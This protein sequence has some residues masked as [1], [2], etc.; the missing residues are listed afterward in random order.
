[1]LV[2]ALCAAVFGAGAAYTQREIST[3]GISS[4]KEGEIVSG[5]ARIPLAPESVGQYQKIV[6]EFEG[7]KEDGRNLRLLARADRFGDFSRGQQLFARCAVKQA[8]EDIDGF[9]YR[10]FLLKD[11]IDGI[12]ADPT[13]SPESKK[14][15]TLAALLDNFLNVFS[16]PLEKFLPQ[17]EAGLAIGML[18]GKTDS[19]SANMQEMFSRT[20]L[21]HIMAVSGSNVTII[22]Q[23]FFLAALSLG[24]WR[25]KASWMAAIGITLF[26]L[27]VGFPASAIRAGIMALLSLW[28]R[29]IGRFSSAWRALVFAS[30]LMVAFNPLILRF[31]AGFQLSVLAT[32]GMISLNPVACAYVSKGKGKRFLWEIFSTTCSAQ[33]FV[34][35]LIAYSFGSV[36]VVALLA[37]ML[38]LPVVPL[39]MAFSLLVS[40]GGALNGFLG[41]AAAILAYPVLHW[42]SL[43]ASSFGKLSFASREI[44]FAWQAAVL[45]YLLILSGVFALRSLVARKK[46]YVEEGL[47]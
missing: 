12:C 31:D 29:S 16:R 6:L 19:L 35:P 38:V 42:E 25:G 45:S 47:F 30:A 27:M 3:A 32:A 2:A 15:D 10:M 46:D 4:Y 1:M 20:G 8:E 17:P 13:F 33:L 5:Q 21:T 11:G 26:V 7:L 14:A 44:S 24:M 34:Y 36:S 39:A 28:A 18:F 9:N 40:L 23:Y 22:G 41:G 37:N 43:V